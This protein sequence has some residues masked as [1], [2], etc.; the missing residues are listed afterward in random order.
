MNSLKEYTVTQ[1]TMTVLTLTDMLAAGK[2][3]SL[4]LDPDYQRNVVWNYENKNAFID[5]TMK[6]IIPA[7]ITF[8]DEEEGGKTCI[9]GKQRCTALKE[10]VNNV[11]P[12]TFEN[13]DIVEGV[14]FFGPEDDLEEKYTKKYKNFSVLDKK[15][16]SDF[17]N[18]MIPLTTYKHLDYQDQIDIFN[19]MQ[20]GKKLSDGELLACRFSETKTL[21]KFNDLCKKYETKQ[22][23]KFF[24]KMDRKEHHLFFMRLLCYIQNGLQNTNKKKIDKFIT[25]TDNNT[26]FPSLVVT[27][28][29]LTGLT[30][31]DLLLNNAKVKKIKTNTL[32]V[33]IYCLHKKN[34]VNRLNDRKICCSLIT[35][36]NNLDIYCCSLKG[37]KTD[38][39]LREMEKKF[40][41]LYDKYCTNVDD[42]I[43]EDEDDNDDA[44]VED[45][46]E[47]E[48]IVTK[49]VVKINSSMQS[50]N[51]TK[52]MLTK[53]IN[54]KPK[55]NKK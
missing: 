31:T 41:S 18:R 6:N 50:N 47:E 24:K 20:Y 45:D 3:M 52:D 21:S 28:D 29:K 15:K 16:R 38:D 49:P 48:I 46:C 26:K 30:F 9:D 1:T 19:R 7:N 10:F 43:I 32:E 53:T 13:N 17:L 5:S 4:N 33:F 22:L 42:G 34:M 36:I 55:A 27:L 8:N 40:N 2:K 44:I 11:I 25:N 35:V 39:N 54:M 37:G 51:K 23:T 14:Y 12:Y